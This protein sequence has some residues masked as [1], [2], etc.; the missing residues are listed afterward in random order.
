M[1]RQR[2]LEVIQQAEDVT[3]G[4]LVRLTDVRYS[5]LKYYTE[6][7]CSPSS[8]RRKTS[9]GGTSGRPASAASGGSKPSGRR[10]SPSPRSRPFS[11]WRMPPPRHNQ[12]PGSQTI[13]CPAAGGFLLGPGLPESAGGPVWDR[14]RLEPATWFPA[15]SRRGSRLSRESP[16]AKS[17]GDAPPPWV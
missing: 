3:I 4:E 17:R 5:T 15:R 7:G 6:E 14:R 11:R 16:D 12:N 10:G 2:K 8:R 13:P 9:P 1:S